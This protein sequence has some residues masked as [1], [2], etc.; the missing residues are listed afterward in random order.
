[1]SD[2]DKIAK[3]RARQEAAKDRNKTEGGPAFPQ[4]YLNPSES[5]KGMTMRDYLAARALAVV[6]DANKNDGPNARAAYD[7]ADAML[8]QREK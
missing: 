3:E 5:M 8:A 2:N 6:F 4:T 7:L 1:M